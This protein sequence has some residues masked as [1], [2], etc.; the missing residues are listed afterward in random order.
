MIAKKLKE[1]LNLENPPIAIKF[2]WQGEKI[3]EGFE[4]LNKKIRFCQA[5]MEAK[6]GRDIAISPL[7]MACG[8]GPASFGAPIKEKVI[9]GEAHFSLGLFEKPEAAAKCL[10][11]NIKM[12]PGAISYVLISQLEKE[13]INPDVVLITLFP[14]QAMWICHTWSY[15]NGRHLKIELQT[16]SSV[17]S[18]LTVASFLRNEIQIGLGCYGSRNSTDIKKEEMYVAIPGS[19]LLETVEILEKLIKPISDSRSKRIFHETYSK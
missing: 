9:R 2:I 4:I 3:P 19:M 5:V 1:I 13:L 18:G 12:M 14:E 11:G 6:W 16:E 15:K 8:P 10:G 17:C 7:E